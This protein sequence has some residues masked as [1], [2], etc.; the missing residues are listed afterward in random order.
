MCVEVVRKTDALLLIILIEY[1][2]INLACICKQ[3]I[4][5]TWY[6]YV[7]VRKDFKLFSSIISEWFVK[8]FK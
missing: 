7:S 8:S 1:S 6:N 5:F 3:I 4:S 2:C